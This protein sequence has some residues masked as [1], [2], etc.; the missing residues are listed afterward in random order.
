[1]GTGGNGFGRWRFP[2]GTV[3]QLRATA[4]LRNPV[5][6]L[7]TT[8]GKVYKGRVVEGKVSQWEPVLGL[9]EV[10]SIFVNPYNPNCAWV[11]DFQDASIKMT[12]NGGTSWTPLPALK[13]IATN[14]GEYRFDCG[15]W[16][17]RSAGCRLAAITQMSS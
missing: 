2:H 7:L 9:G 3:A 5:L 15:W 11:M 10:G 13:A 16:S 4:G 12:T 8:A 6:W 17:V 14:N 1:M